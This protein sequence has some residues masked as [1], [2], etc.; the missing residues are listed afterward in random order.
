MDNFSMF[1]CLPKQPSM[2]DLSSFEQMKQV[3]NGI[4]GDADHALRRTPFLFNLSYYYF[5][6]LFIKIL[7]FLQCFPV[8]FLNKNFLSQLKKYS[9]K[10]VCTAAGDNCT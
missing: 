3:A 6:L 8:S 7:K 5:I 4:K 1:T 2:L 10:I 9:G